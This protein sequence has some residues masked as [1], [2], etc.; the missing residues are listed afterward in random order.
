MKPWMEA[1]V[2]YRKCERKSCMM[3]LHKKKQMGEGSNTWMW[4]VYNTNMPINWLH[5]VL[6]VIHTFITWG[7]VHAAEH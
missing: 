1:V 4:V 5:S 6:V 2:A 7:S 3:C